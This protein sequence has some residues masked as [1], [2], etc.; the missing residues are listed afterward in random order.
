MT[1]DGEA[2]GELWQYS[3]RVYAREGV[4]GALLALQD[5]CGAD[6]NMLLYCC[7]IAATGRARLAEE[8]IQ[9]ADAA[10]ERWRDAVTLPLRRIRDRIKSTPALWT[11]TGAAHTRG[12]V[13]AAELESECVCQ[14]VLERLAPPAAATPDTVAKRRAA[15]ASLDAYLAFLGRSLD[16]R[17]RRGVETLLDNAF[18]V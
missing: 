4:S 1:D 17:D 10:I 18:V 5:R 11:Q 13:L 16:E 14:E 15:T 3:L 2:G 6:V 9:R 12:K 7:W 8:D